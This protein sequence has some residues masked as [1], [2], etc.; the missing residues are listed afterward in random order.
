MA[1]LWIDSFS[2][3]EK[4]GSGS[5]LYDEAFIS[6]L[7]LRFGSS[8]PSLLRLSHCTYPLSQRTA[9]SLPW[10]ATYKTTGKGFT[11][12]EGGKRQQST[13]QRLFQLRE[14]TY[15]WPTS[16]KSSA[17]VTRSVFTAWINTN[18][19]ISLPSTSLIENRIALN[20]SYSLRSKGRAFVNHPTTQTRYQGCDFYGIS[21]IVTVYR[22]A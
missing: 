7:P 16:S 19:S 17:S 14:R 12:G 4:T 15:D 20:K 5:S 13:S 11:K 18:D 22:K 3:C 8:L 6:T 1:T 21:F 2:E 10:K 9:R